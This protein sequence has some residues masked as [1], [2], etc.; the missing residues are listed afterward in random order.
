MHANLFG[1]FVKGKDLSAYNQMVQE[2]IILHRNIDA[3]IGQHSKVKE[4]SKLLSPSLPKVSSI[5]IDIYFDHFLAKNW[6]DYHHQELNDFLANFY[7]Y[8]INETDYPNEL[9]L[10]TLFRLK[11]GQWIS[12]YNTLQGIEYV[13]RGVSQRIS[14]PNALKN[15][16][17]VLE[18]NYNSVE[19]T[20][21]H[22]MKDAIDYFQS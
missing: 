5:A 10:Q 18:N 1:D 9:F 7:T 11:K 13:C 6:N 22:F 8:K 4:L 20:F 15:G 3:F 19:E 16:R 14:F 12:E 21:K 17:M 2:G